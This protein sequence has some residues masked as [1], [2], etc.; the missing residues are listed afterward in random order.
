MK[1]TENYLSEISEI[2]KMMQESSRFLTLSGLSG[3]LVGIYALA[4]AV[5]ADSLLFTSHIFSWL[6]GNN[7][8]ADLSVLAGIILSLSIITIVILTSIRVKK[9]GKKFWNIG[10][11]QMLLNLSVPL[12]SGGLLIIVFV[13]KGFYEIVVPGTLVFYGLS[14]VNAAK[15]TRN[16]IFYLGLFQ[17]ILGIVAAILP[18][19]GILLWALGF[20]L[21]HIIYGV[22]M[23][24]RYE[25]S[26]KG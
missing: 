12:L 20:G 11:R 13:F 23:Y 9:A 21:L 22:L 18:S 3:I 7:V 14:L 6:K 17:L 16:E 1:T 8:V 4:G 2:R 25:Y 10:S 24:F 5:M 26:P 15:F 19:I